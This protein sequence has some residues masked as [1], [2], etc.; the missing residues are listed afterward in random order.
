MS[1]R[2]I[3]VSWDKKIVA[4]DLETGQILV[5]LLLEFQTSNSLVLRSS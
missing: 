5:T 1:V 3:T 4:L 2:I